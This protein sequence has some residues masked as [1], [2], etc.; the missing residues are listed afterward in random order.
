MNRFRILSSWKLHL[1]L[2]FF[3]IFLDQ[4]SKILAVAVLAP[5]FENPMG[6]VV[7]VFG[8]LLRFRLAYNTGAA[9]SSRPQDLLPFLS[10]TVF[11]LVLSVI[12]TFVLVWFYRSLKQGD[13]LARMGIAMIVSGAL[14][15]FADR[16]RIGKVVDFIDCDF[17]DFIMERWPT[18]NVADCCVTVGV[19]VVLLSPVFYKFLKYTPTGG[20]NGQKGTDKKIS[21]E[22]EN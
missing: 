21:G 12:A 8:D 7:P 11:F 18:F 20:R 13:F 6:R 2:V 5:T 3:A 9:F 1:T 4:A 19:A 10:P 14:G 22:K 15:N 16:M 17:P